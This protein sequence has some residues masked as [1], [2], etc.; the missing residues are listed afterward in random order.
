MIDVSEFTAT[1]S[2]VIVQASSTIFSGDAIHSHSESLVPVHHKMNGLC[3]VLYN[4]FAAYLIT[5]RV[6]DTSLY[7]FFTLTIMAIIEINLLEI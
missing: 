1:E 6:P 7:F 4:I 2:G 5:D 3:Q